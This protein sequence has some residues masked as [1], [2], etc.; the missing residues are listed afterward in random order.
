LYHPKQKFEKQPLNIKIAK[1]NNRGA[2]SQI[3]K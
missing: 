3:L 1:F 2:R